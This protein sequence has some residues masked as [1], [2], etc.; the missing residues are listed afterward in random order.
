MRFFNTLSGQP[1]DFQPLRDKIAEM[2]TCGPTVYDFAHIGNLRTY[3][4]EDILRRALISNG[5]RVKQVMNITD[6]DD[7]IIRRATEEKIDFRKLTRRFEKYFFEDLRSLNIEPAEKYPRATDHIPEMIRLIAILVK[8][9]IAYRGE[10]HS[11]YF[12]IADFPAYG[13]LSRLDRRELKIGARVSSDE[14]DK[15]EARDFVLW[16]AARPGEP[17]WPSPWGPGRPGW[18]IECSAMSMKYLGPTFDLHTGGVDNIFPHHENE[19]AQSE[20][21][22]GKK[23]VNY[24]LHGEHLLVDGEKMSK[25]LG[26]F[27]TL[28][29]LKKRGFEPLSFRYL[30]LN[31]HYRTKLNFSWEALRSGQNS[32]NNLRDEIVRLKLLGKLRKKPSSPPIEIKR[33][34]KDFADA[35]NDDLNTSRGLGV[36]WEAVRDEKLNPATRIGLANRFDRIL[37]LGLEG[38]RPSRVPLLIRRLQRRRELSRRNKQFIQSDRLRKR[39]EELGYRIED[40]AEGPLVMK[41]KK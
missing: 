29:D 36:L 39:M 25:S 15:E 21:A 22:T 28:A 5:F 18:H 19:I 16:K 7:K 4:F 1:E 30:C 27:F 12:R 35:I 23:F 13:R 33:Y 9:G 31:T 11:I 24:W 10:D 6:I 38:I 20:A 3:V 26:N 17:S 40:T 41:I 14:Y 8:K 37:G 34:E 32:L 2:Y